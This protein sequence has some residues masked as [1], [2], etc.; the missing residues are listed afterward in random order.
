MQRVLI[1]ISMASWQ[2]FPDAVFE[3]ILSAAAAAP[4]DV[5]ACVALERRGRH[6]AATLWGLAARL[7]LGPT[8]CA[9]LRSSSGG[10]DGAG[11]SAVSLAIRGGPGF[12]E[13]RGATAGRLECRSAPKAMRA[14]QAARS[15][16]AAVVLGQSKV[17]IFGG[18]RDSEA[19]ADPAVLDLGKCQWLAVQDQTPDGPCAGPGPRLRAS[20]TALSDRESSHQALLLGGQTWAGVGTG[21]P[22]GDC[23]TVTCRIET[24]EGDDVV[25]WTWSELAVSGDLPEA[26]ACHLAVMA[27]CGLLVVGGVGARGRVL[28]CDAYCLA[29]DVWRLP[30]QSGLFPPQGAL[31]HGAVHGNRLILV[32]G[33]DEDG[34]QRR[35][36][37]RPTEVH[38]LDLSTWAWQRLARQTLTPPVHSRA[39]SLVLAGKLFIVGGDIGGLRSDSNDVAV[40]DLASQQWLP[41]GRVE[42]AAFRASG[43]TVQG[44]VVIGGLRREDAEAP[45]AFLVPTSVP[46]SSAA[47]Q[48]DVVAAA[49]VPPQKK[50]PRWLKR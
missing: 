47:M 27:P 26:R 45:V 40:L 23:W 31:H 15:G 46:K 38:V 28:C 49:A 18:I 6:L 4:L 12:E 16:H 39:A 8:V 2:F 24:I 14:S 29:D 25:H 5:Q 41:S 48:S 11:G 36:L 17:A 42:G 35:G 37:G 30:A 32:G 3:R 44:G 22:Y 9:A 50:I 19:V 7:Q 21:T 20:F 10:V 1:V 43:H 13:L 34:L 33:I